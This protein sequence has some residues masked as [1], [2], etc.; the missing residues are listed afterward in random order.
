[1]NEPKSILKFSRAN[2]PHF[3]TNHRRS[4]TEA[5]GCSTG[6]QQIKQLNKFNVL[7]SERKFSKGFQLS[8]GKPDNFY[9]NMISKK[10][11]FSKQSKMRKISLGF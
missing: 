7:N 9:F 2:S 8:K 1:M 4:Q 5:S 3:Y 10:S 6:K 11:I